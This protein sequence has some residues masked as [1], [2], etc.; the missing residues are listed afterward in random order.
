MNKGFGKAHAK[1]ILVGEHAVVYGYPAVALPLLSSQVHVQV[2]TH[3]QTIIKS[4]YFNGLVSDL[5]DMFEPIKALILK[6]KADLKINHCLIEINTTIPLSAGLGSSAAIA[7]AITEAF[8]D[9]QK[10]PLSFEKRFEYVQFSETLAHQ[11]PSGIDA[12]ITMTDTPILFKKG[13]PLKPYPFKLNAFLVVGN[14]GV[15]GQT[16]KA[17]SHIAKT[18]DSPSTKSLIDQLGLCANDA[19][20]AI[21]EGSLLALGNLLTLA[22]QT[23]DALSVSHPLLNQMVEDSLSKGAIGAKMTG[24]GLGGCAIALCQ[25]EAIAKHIQESWAMLSGQ[26]AFILPI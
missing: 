12:Q 20:T 5:D 8:F 17:V 4:D 7:S 15:K 9:Y 6:L 22:H 16:K 24:G 26:I 19:I 13:E 18:I 21:N 10:T 3:N 23:L 25:N 2:S 14:T 11:N 1:I